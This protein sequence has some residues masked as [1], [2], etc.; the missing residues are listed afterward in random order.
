[1]VAA[2]PAVTVPIATSL[3]VKTGVPSQLA[4]TDGP[5]TLNVTDPVAFGVRP[6]R[7]ATSWIV[8]EGNFPSVAVVL[9]AGLADE[10]VDVSPSS[11]QVPAT[12][13][14]FGSPE[15]VAIQ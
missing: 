6:F 15:Y 12:A 1:M 4:L 5:Q 2:S 11:P 13:L 7:C 14:L 3:S 9:M 8:P 10:T